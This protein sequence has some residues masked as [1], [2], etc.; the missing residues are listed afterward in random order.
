MGGILNSVTD[1]IADGAS[2]IFDTPTTVSQLPTYQGKSTGAKVAQFAWEVFLT[3]TPAI[4]T[5]YFLYLKQQYL[6]KAKSF[7]TNTEESQ[8][9]TKKAQICS[10]L[11]IPFV[12]D[13][14]VPAAFVGICLYVVYAGR[15]R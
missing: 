1:F 10:K 2:V 11:A 3:L 6:A 9:A 13:V 7:P 15:M 8:A 12:P 5:G 4:S 14:V